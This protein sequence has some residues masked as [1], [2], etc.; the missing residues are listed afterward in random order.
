VGL[1][2]GDCP[3]HC[4]QYLPKK[5]GEAAHAVILRDPL[6][7]AWVKQQTPNANVIAIFD[8]HF[9]FAASFVYFEN[10]YNPY[11]SCHT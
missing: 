6:Y 10:A 5:V 2:G 7:L 1:Y 3:Q 4:K 11:R 9:F 8:C